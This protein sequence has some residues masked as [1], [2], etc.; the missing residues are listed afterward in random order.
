MDGDEEHLEERER[1][2]WSPSR[3]DEM[4]K[5]M[6]SGQRTYLRTRRE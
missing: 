6:S 4:Q 5:K 2:T 3:V 1:R